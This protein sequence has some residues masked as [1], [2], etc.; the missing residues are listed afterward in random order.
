MHAQCFVLNQLIRRP[1]TFIIRRFHA[2]LFINAS[3]IAPNP[4]KRRH[5][6]VHSFVYLL[7]QLHMA[8]EHLQ[9]CQLHSQQSFSID[10]AKNRPSMKIWVKVTRFLSIIG[11][12]FD[13]FL[14]IFTQKIERQKKNEP[15]NFALI[16]R[17]P[18]NQIH[19]ICLM[20]RFWFRFSFLFPWRNAIW[21][22]W[23]R[24]LVLL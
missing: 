5:F 19:I 15:L 9:L 13:T 8:Q 24:Y 10:W 1:R 17:H 2:I 3:A 23:H 22:Q 12:V 21:E 4:Q 20:S 16:S 14:L 6:C 18:K 11:N 7:I